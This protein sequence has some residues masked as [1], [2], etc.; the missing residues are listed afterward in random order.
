[1]V[2]RESTFFFPFPVFPLNSHDAACFK[3]HMLTAQGYL[4]LGM[5]FARWKNLR[6]T[7]QQVRVTGDHEIAIAQSISLLLYRIVSSSPTTMTRTVSL[8]DELIPYVLQYLQDPDDPPYIT[9]AVS[10]LRSAALVSRAWVEPAQTLLFHHLILNLDPDDHVLDPMQLPRIVFVAFHPH[11][12]RKIRLLVLYKFRKDYHDTAVYSPSLT[13]VMSWLPTT[14]P[15]IKEFSFHDFTVNSPY[16]C[17]FF[18]H[19]AAW[20]TIRIVKADLIMRPNMVL[21]DS[22]ASEY[23]PIQRLSLSIWDIDDLNFV[24]SSLQ[25]TRAAQSLRHL[26]TRSQFSLNNRS[27]EANAAIFSS[28]IGLMAGFSNLLS[29]DIDVGAYEESFELC[30]SSIGKQRV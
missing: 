27:A 19:I 14:I 28:F 26:C 15:W 5:S 10:Y 29:L 8:L 25:T 9:P 12:L 3:F 17:S 2:R 13:D 18:R 23:P 1:M 30:I 7:A 21:E 16:A 6:S 22:H 4:K 20:T 11:L 24:L